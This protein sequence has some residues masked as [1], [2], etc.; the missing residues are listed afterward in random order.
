MKTSLFKEI[1]H[2]HW[3]CNDEMLKVG[4]AY[5]IKEVVLK[6]DFFK[7]D[8]KH[9]ELKKE[10]VKA[11]KRLKEYEHNASKDKDDLEFECLNDSKGLNNGRTVHITRHAL[12]AKVGFRIS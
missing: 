7:D 9:K 4:V 6:D 10:F 12:N 11:Y 3:M 8:N 1:L 2:A 5:Y